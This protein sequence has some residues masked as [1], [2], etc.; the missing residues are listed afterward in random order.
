[1]SPTTPNLKVAVLGATGVVG[2]EFLKILE[3]RKTPIGELRLFASSRSEGLTVPFRGQSITVRAPFEGCFKGCDV[4]F[5]SAGTSLSEVWGPI[6]VREGCMVIDNSAAFRMHEDVPLVVPEVNSNRLPPT[7]KPSLIAN[8]NCST[9]QLVVALKPLHQSF[10]LKSVV[11]SSYQS[12]S[13]AGIEGIDE[14]KNNTDSF[15]KNNPESKSIFPHNIAFNNIPQI[16]VFDESGFTKEEKKIMLESRK[17]LEIPDLNISAT[18]VRTPTLN[19]HSEA[20]WVELKKTTS[21]DDLISVLKNAE[22]IE[23]LDDPKTLTYPLNR[24]ASGTDPVFIGRIRQDLFT[25]NRWVMWI[26]ADNVRKGAALNGVQIAEKLYF[27][28]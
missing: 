20:V 21:R 27:S 2:K 4:A 5:F 9:I 13:G 1:M 6:A 12:V 15:L 24:Q 17:I 18:A 8:P 28:N 10:G 14:L 11:V 26:V 7:S 23:V 19:S 22:G 25:P 3:E 16:D